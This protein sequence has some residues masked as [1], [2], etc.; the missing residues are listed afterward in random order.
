MVARGAPTE[1]GPGPRGRGAQR[2]TLAPE[3]IGGWA[4]PGPRCLPRC[5]ALRVR[6]LI[7]SA[8][9]A[10]AAAE[11]R[12]Q[13]DL[14]SLSRQLKELSVQPGSKACCPYELLKYRICAGETLL[15]TTLTPLGVS[16]TPPSSNGPSAQSAAGPRC[17]CSLV[18]AQGS[19]SIHARRQLREVP[20]VYAGPEIHQ[21][22]GS[23][24][25]QFTHSRSHQPPSLPSPGFSSPKCLL[26]SPSRGV[27][28]AL[29]LPAGPVF[30]SQ[31]P[32]SP[33]RRCGLAILQLP[34]DAVACAPTAHPPP[35]PPP[36][37]GVTAATRTCR[38]VAWR[39]TGR[40]SHLTVNLASEHPR[41]RGPGAATSAVQLW[42]SP[43]S[44]QGLGGC[45]WVQRRHGKL[46]GKLCKLLSPR[47]RGRRS[48]RLQQRRRGPQA[49]FVH[50][51]AAR[52][53][54]DGREVLQPALRAPDPPGP[55][56]LPPAFEWPDLR[57]SSRNPSMDGKP[58]P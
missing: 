35:P 13:D 19:R 38:C 42:L 32:E 36:R 3:R 39:S 2:R 7:G 31:G 52:P 25:A 55:G 12:S 23:E 21:V 11:A 48:E 58:W 9:A 54:Q 57:G 49:G 51:G 33:Q 28:A 56:P 44:C 6:L 45:P 10:A 27:A 37:A 14:N 47:Q 1:R 18:W 15:F 5:A 34:A 29:G 16:S 20:D 46:R 24:L 30:S 4:E 26:V 43:V 17:G 50:R 41:R 22:P 53:P 8:A 40:N